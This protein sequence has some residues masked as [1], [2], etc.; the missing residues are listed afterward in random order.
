MIHPLTYPVSGVI[1]P[2][3]PA[4]ETVENMNA[5]TSNGIR[6]CVNTTT[7]DKIATLNYPSNLPYWMLLT[8][9]EKN[10]VIQVAFDLQQNTGFRRVSN[11]SGKTWSNWMSH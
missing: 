4:G 11:N 9:A 8:F 2:V 1:K 3:I 10:V 6:L 7:S 5:L